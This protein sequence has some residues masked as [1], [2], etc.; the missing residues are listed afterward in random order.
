MINKMHAKNSDIVKKIKDDIKI[1]NNK[2]RRIKLDIEEIDNQITSTKKNLIKFQNLLKTKEIKDNK[3][4]GDLSE[5]KRIKRNISH[6]EYKLYNFNKFKFLYENRNSDEQALKIWNEKSDR[7]SNTIQKLQRYKKSLEDH[8]YIK[9]ERYTLTNN[10]KNEKKVNFFFDYEFFTSV[11]NETYV[12]YNI[13]DNFFKKHAEYSIKQELGIYEAMES[14]LYG[15]GTLLFDLRFFDIDKGAANFSKE[16]AKDWDD[17][18][19]SAIYDGMCGTLENLYTIA[20]DYVVISGTINPNEE[21]ASIARI[22]FEGYI[23]DSLKLPVN[24]VNVGGGA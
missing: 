8:P 4:L 3:T 10:G 5:I 16:M 12:I 18:T 17:E 15:I 7:I 2:I 1:C 22:V 11:D 6:Y 13:L 24:E 19:A 20:K 14:F 9:E 23:E 21:L